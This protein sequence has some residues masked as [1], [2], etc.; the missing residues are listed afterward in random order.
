MQ[1]TD[2]KSSLRLAATNARTW[3]ESESTAISAD[4]FGKRSE[5]GK[6]PRCAVYVYYGTAGALYVGHTKRGLK[7][8]IYDQT[9]PHAKKPW[10]S[11]WHTVRYLP[12]KEETDRLVLEMMLVLA[13][14]PPYNHK[15]AGKRVDDLFAL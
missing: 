13:Y 4:E 8:R 14:Q 9:S 7:A 3:F 10:W 12:I 2:L 6:A 1:S 11:Q 15:P 5:K